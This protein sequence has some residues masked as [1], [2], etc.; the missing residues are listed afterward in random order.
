MLLFVLL[1]VLAR[2][3]EFL[4]L[5]CL[6][7]NRG[8]EEGNDMGIALSY[9]FASTLLTCEDFPRLCVCAAPLLLVESGWISLD[10][11]VGKTVLITSHDKIGWGGA[12]TDNGKGDDDDDNACFEEIGGAGIGKD[13]KEEDSNDID[14][15][16]G[17][18]DDGN[19]NGNDKNGGNGGI[20]EDDEDEST[21]TED[22]EGTM[23]TKGWESLIDE[24]EGMEGARIAISSP[25]SISI[26]SPHRSKNSHASES[27]NTRCLPSRDD[28]NDG[29]H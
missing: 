10:G 26:D 19:G 21:A 7:S 9:D 16:D 29:T 4:L 25:S 6:S 22:T 12:G 1:L 24:D 13:D 2:W 23:V 20:I 15:D 18:D 11:M 14:D 17:D 8:L 5:M 3:L 28:F 27:Y